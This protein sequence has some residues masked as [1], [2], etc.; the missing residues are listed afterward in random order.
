LE[1]IVEMQDKPSVSVVLGQQSGLR[2]SDPAWLA[3]DLANTVLG[4]S[5]TS[6][7]MGN[8]RDRDGLTYGI[9]SRLAGDTFRHGM[10]FIRAT[11]APALLEKG[12]AST[13]RELDSWWKDG[14][15]PAELDYRK[16]AVVGQFTVS[17][18]T[19]E[20]LAEQ[21]LRCA[22]RGFEV[23]WLDEFPGKVRALT[24]EEVNGAIKKQLDPEKMVIV[25]AGTLPK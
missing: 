17:L 10:W 23:K 14:V 21:L 3:L 12:L 4:R 25:K 1:K 11:F 15:T 2:A 7:L 5:F 22:E 16:S 6:R 20:G 24:L 18:E 13:R 8:V 19:S 9:G